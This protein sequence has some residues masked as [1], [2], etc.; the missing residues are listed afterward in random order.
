MQ[1]RT[2]LAIAAGVAGLTVAATALTSRYHDG[3]PGVLG[4]A[5]LGGAGLALTWRR[6]NPGAVLAAV[7]ALTLAY[8][9]LDLP[10]GPVFLP[11]IVAFFSAHLEGRRLAAALSLAGGWIGFA[12][13]APLARGDAVTAGGA[14]SLAA[15]LLVLLGAAE[16]IRWR[17]AYRAE[18][19]RAR[20]DEAR[21]QRGEERLRIARELHDVLAHDISLINVQAGVALHLIDERPEQARDALAAIKH[22]SKDALGELRSVLEALRADGPAPRAPTAGLAR[23]DEVVAGAAAAGL[24]LDTE[25]EG[26]PA[27][28]PAAVDLA[29]FRIVQEA[30]TNVIRH[31]GTASAAVRLRYEPGDLVVEVCDEGVGGTVNG[32]GNGLAGMAERAAALGGTLAAGPRSGGGFRVYARLPRSTPGASPGVSPPGLPGETSPER[33]GDEAARRGRS[34]ASP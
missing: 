15:W 11:L 14:G 4:F 10:G 16:A 29:A 9:L 32:H 12:F 22:A 17:R 8:W 26:D 31:A 19:R 5:L 24:R 7:L 13:L 20:E 33:S 27:P 1:R 2:D 30:V 25:I 6:D 28:L 34:E 18:A 21:R 3:T 23:L